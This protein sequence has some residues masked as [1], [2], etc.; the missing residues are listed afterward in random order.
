[1]NSLI[2]ATNLLR[3]TSTVTPQNI[4]PNRRN[5]TNSSYEASITL[6]SKVDKA[7]K[8]RKKRENY[9][10]LLLMNTDISFQENTA[11]SNSNN[12]PK[13]SF[14]RMEKWLNSKEH[15][16]VFQRIQHHHKDS[17]LFVTPVPRDPLPSGW[18]QMTQTWSADMH[19]GKALIHIKWGVT[20]ILHDWVSFQEFKNNKKYV[21]HL[22]IHSNISRS[23]TTWWYQQMK[24]RSI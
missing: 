13:G 23:E 22:V 2:N 10:P 21:N 7:K 9:R 24:K 14:M 19:T 4:P 11:E 1:M 3:K 8:E 17:Q 16:L 15:Y 18:P 6:V 12:T 5:L 20:F